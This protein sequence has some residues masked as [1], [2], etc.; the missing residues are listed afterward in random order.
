[1]SSRP[2]ASATADYEA[3]EHRIEAAEAEALRARWEFGKALLVERAAN[4]GKQLPNGRLD[5]VAAAVGKSRSE[6][7]HRMRFAER[8]PT[9]AEVAKALAT[10]KTW[11]EVIA[12]LALPVRQGAIGSAPVIRIHPDVTAE[13]EARRRDSERLGDYLRSFDADNRQ[14]GAGPAARPLSAE[15][16]ELR[17]ALRQMEAG[18]TK[19]RRLA[20]KETY[21]LKLQALLAEL[22]PR[23]VDRQLHE[24]RWA[25]DVI[26]LAFELMQPVKPTVAPDIRV[27]E[28]EVDRYADIELPM[29]P[30]TAG[31]SETNGNGGGRA[32]GRRMTEPEGTRPVTAPGGVRN[33]IGTRRPLY[34][35]SVNDERVIFASCPPELYARVMQA[36][37]PGRG[38][39]SAL[40]SHGSAPVLGGGRAPAV[41]SIRWREGPASS[42][43]A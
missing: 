34:L 10:S 25:H 6:I 14:H 29:T 16:T 39:L 28:M 43:A 21:G 7:D 20:D 37:G 17:D 42:S 4:G 26:K 32:G 1:V 5:E 36:A 27:I 41:S 9:E 22:P 13:L 30:L 12:A 33:R 2:K 35:V 19:I 38:R 15:A 24:T 3:L 11:R 40:R 18:A 23:A 8:Y 31:T